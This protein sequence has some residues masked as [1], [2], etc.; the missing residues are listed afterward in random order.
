M[1]VKIFLMFCVATTA[2]A[3]VKQDEKSEFIHAVLGSVTNVGREISNVITDDPDKLSVDLNKMYSKYE[4]ASKVNDVKNMFKDQVRK[5]ADSVYNFVKKMDEELETSFK[6]KADMIKKDD[7]VLAEKLNKIY[8][9]TCQINRLY[10]DIVKY[11][12]DP[13]KV[14]NFFD[15]VKDSLEPVERKM[16]EVVKKLEAMAIERLPSKSKK[17]LN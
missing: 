15:K 8:D 13:E 5:N 4:F 3:F 14:S 10:E 11:V 7:P 9:L 17:R 12:L 16:V 1:L 6:K 2:F